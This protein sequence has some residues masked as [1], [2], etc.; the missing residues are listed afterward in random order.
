MRR[1]SE[2]RSSACKCR[3]RLYPRKRSNADF[4]TP[5]GV[6]IPSR[7]SE[8]LLLTP[9]TRAKITH[10]PA[11]ESIRDDAESNKVTVGSRCQ[12]DHCACA[13]PTPSH[14][15][16]TWAAHLTEAR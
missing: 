3:R 12:S 14:R 9:E 1:N 8:A 7:P 6:K 16:K 11:R 2:G 5:G 4:T 13:N 10:G 15:A